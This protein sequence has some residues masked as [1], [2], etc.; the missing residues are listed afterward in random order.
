MPRVIIPAILI[1]ALLTVLA[2]CGGDDPTATAA[3]TPTPAPTATPVPPT[4]MPDPTPTAMPGA[5]ATPAPQPTDT[6]APTA[7]APA[8]VIATAMPEPTPIPPTATP[9]PAPAATEPPVM[10]PEDLLAQYA[11][12]VAGG[13]G[14]IAVG[15]PTSQAFYAQL[16]GPPA[17]DGLYI[18]PPEQQAQFQPLFQAAIFGAAPLGIP[19]HQFIYTSDY[20][21][22]LLEKANF[23]NPTE[24]TSSGENIE[25]QYV[26][27]S[28]NLPTCV[29]K[30]AYFAPRLA[31]RT[32]GQVTLSITSFPELSGSG[33]AGIVAESLTLVADGTLDM[34]NIYTGYVAGA[35]PAIE[36][37]S[38]WGMGPDWES[39]YLALA[40]M[41][42]DVERMLV[43]ETG[44]V[45]VNRNWYAGA[46]QWFFSNEPIMSA[47]DFQGKKVR[48]HSA[49]LSSLIEGLGA[50][51]LFIPPG[52]DYLALQNG[53]VDIGTTGALLALAGR[54]HE[55]SDYMAGPVI[56]FG[57]TNNVINGDLWDRIPADL[58]Q[59]II[60][61]G[62]RMELEEL[63]IAPYHNIVP[64][65]ANQALGVSP[66]I[67]SEE[68]ITYIAGVVLPQ[69][70][71]PDWLNRLGYPER[72]QDAV[73][74]FNEHAGP[75]IGLRIADDGSVERA[76]ITKGPRAQ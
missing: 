64:I 56:G 70:I 30:Q 9:E 67:F 22:E 60:E 37:Q 74:I 42:P 54:Y 3:P 16:I 13:P 6:P 47:A 1:I 66:V 10:T 41:A 69:N 20:Y 49:A 44:G 26:C 57:Y 45:I 52:A 14:A 12:S 31:A 33:G 72:N 25:I 40:D 23:L 71:I 53:T 59:I 39:T 2:A 38:L 24:L 29:M 62:A 34:V 28:R 32:N 4:A 58:Q 21:R 46:D 36:V 55:I 18:L 5:T 61:E 76:P 43:D 75:Y 8:A 65:I 15:D 7:A 27:L 17:H 35:L 73:R 68:I 11:A 51:P 19:G 48:S 63:R 50:E